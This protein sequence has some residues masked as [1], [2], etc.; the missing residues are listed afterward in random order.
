MKTNI[1]KSISAIVILTWFCSFFLFSQQTISFKNKNGTVLRAEIDPKTG[2]AKRISDIRDHVRQYG[3]EKDKLTIQTVDNLAKQLIDN[4][5]S[6]LKISS[7]N[8]RSKKIESDGDWW[9]VDY[10]QIYSG[11]PVYNSEISFTVDPQ[12]IIISLGAKAFPKI[13]VQTKAA[14]TS[15]Q[16]LTKSS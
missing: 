7:K 1:L 14:I 10:E 3:F 9:F 16:A 4:Y 5:T 15:T 6:V 8:M 13:D 11:L 12:G 2:C